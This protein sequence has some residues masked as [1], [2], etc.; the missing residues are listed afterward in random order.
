MRTFHTTLA[1]LF[2]SMVWNAILISAGYF[3]GKNW[4]AVITIIK[5]YNQFVI[6]I[7]I[8]FLLF[9]FWKKKKKKQEHP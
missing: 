2:S 3:L 6:I 7:I 5:R 1:A 9:Y 4:Q 8:L